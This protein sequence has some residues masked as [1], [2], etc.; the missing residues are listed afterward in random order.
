M[1]TILNLIIKTKFRRT[2]IEVLILIKSDFLIQI[3]NVSLKYHFEISR[4]K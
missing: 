2:K 4:K 3:V 1:G